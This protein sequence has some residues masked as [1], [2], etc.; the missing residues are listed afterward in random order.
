[1]PRRQELVPAAIPSAP[2]PID[3][4]HASFRAVTPAPMGNPR[5]PAERNPAT[6]CGARRRARRRRRASKDDHTPMTPQPRVA[7]DTGTEILPRRRPRPGRAPRSALTE[8][9]PRATRRASASR[10]STGSPRSVASHRPARARA[11]VPLH[12]D[13]IA[14]PRVRNPN[15]VRAGGGDVPG[16]IEAQ[17]G[18]RAHHDR[19]PR[20][21]RDPENRW[22]RPGTATTFH[23]SPPR[24]GRRGGIRQGDRTRHPAGDVAADSIDAA[25]TAGVEPAG[26]P[27]STTASPDTPSTTPAASTRWPRGAARDVGLHAFVRLPAHVSHPGTRSEPDAHSPK[28]RKSRIRVTNADDPAQDTEVGGAVGPE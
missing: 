11:S 21:S 14:R 8:R 19:H 16:C 17:L 28:Y 2:T 5:P 7:V 24:G 20:C 13:G 4:D 3:P 9:P 23:S 1:M 12:G 25:P 22:R 6:G 27:A 10:P 15:S 18:R 26:A